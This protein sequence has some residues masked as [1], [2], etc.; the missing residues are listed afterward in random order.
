MNDLLYENINK[1]KKAI[2]SNTR[3]VFLVG[4]EYPLKNRLTLPL[5]LSRDV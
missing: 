4:L 2:D 1:L 5:G 3:L